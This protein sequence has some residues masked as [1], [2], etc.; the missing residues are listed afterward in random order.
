MTTMDEARLAPWLRSSRH[1]LLAAHALEGL[2]AADIGTDHGLIP[3]AW[4]KSGLL[5]RVIAADLRPR[6]IQGAAR[7]REQAGLD[8][9]LMPTRVGPGLAVLAPGEAATILIAGMGGATIAQIL[10]DHDARALGARRLILQPNIGQRSLRRA[11]W[12]SGLGPSDELLHPEAG[13]LY[14]VMI[15]DLDQAPQALQAP[16]DE[17][18]WCFGPQV[19]RRAGPVFVRWLHDEIARVQATLLALERAQRPVEQTR[20]AAL[21]EL[22]LLRQELARVS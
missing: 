17:A 2:P 5:P 10:R 19:R 12:A 18:D 3:I 9:A 1:L 15:V 14:P 20:Q 13:R 11:L 7:L 16:Q 8:A 4:L 21:A 6:P 22:A